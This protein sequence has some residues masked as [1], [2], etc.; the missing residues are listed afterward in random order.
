MA[1]IQVEPVDPADESANNTS[2]NSNGTMDANQTAVIQVVVEPS[3]A[4]D[5]IAAIQVVNIKQN[6][7]SASNN[8]TT[9]QA[10]NFVVKTNEPDF[11]KVQAEKPDVVLD[12]TVDAAEDFSTAQGSVGSW[13]LDRIDQVRLLL[14]RG[15]APHV[16]S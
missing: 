1:Q 11:T 5:H 10:R 3:Q 6:T 7:S 9:Q 2:Q 8:G 15:S 12:D 14:S 16:F 13:S 4:S